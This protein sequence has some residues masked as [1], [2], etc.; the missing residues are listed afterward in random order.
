MT[1]LP[2]IVITAHDAN[3]I[4]L[5]NLDS[6]APL[7]DHNVHHTPDL[8][9][10]ITEGNTRHVYTIKPGVDTSGFFSTPGED[11]AYAL[12]AL[13]AYK[14]QANGIQ[15]PFMIASSDEVVSPS[16]AGRAQHYVTGLNPQEVLK[17]LATMWRVTSSSPNE[18]HETPQGTAEEDNPVIGYGILSY[19]KPLNA[20]N[21]G[22]HGFYIRQNDKENVDT[23]AQW[24]S[25][26]T[27]EYYQ[28]NPDFGT[29]L[30]I[31]YGDSEERIKQR[32]EDYQAFSSE[33]AFPVPVFFVRYCEGMTDKL[34]RVK[35]EHD[36]TPVAEREKEGYDPLHE[37]Y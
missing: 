12:A 25:T 9:F 23:L 16:V 26:M 6:R 11:R 1:T 32:F 27:Q 28:C 37:M 34:A 36:D 30:T 20:A 24:F 10:T 18:E 17:R 2:E 21:F 19:K 5:Y 15:G 3:R 4:H 13:A 8:G 33:M 35:R 14:A 22:A 7:N 29:R 31:T